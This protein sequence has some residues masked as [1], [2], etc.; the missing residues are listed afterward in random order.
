MNQAII[1]MDDNTYRIEDGF[2]RL[3][4]VIGSKQALLIDSGAS[5]MDVVA[6]AREVTD[7]PL[8]LLNT[9]GDMDHVARNDL[10]SEFYMHPSDYK[11]CSIEQKFPNSNLIPIEDGQVLDLGNRVLKLISIPGHTYGSVAI[12]D[13]N[14]KRLFV[15]DS[16]QSGHIFMFGE[17]RC[18]DKFKASLEKLMNM[19]EEVKELAASHDTPILPADHIQK[20]YEAWQLVCDGKLES[21]TME[22]HGH[23][24]KSY[25]TES[26]GFYI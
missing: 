24:V 12:Y 23:E 19:K 16:V 10:F 26:C 7:L 2:V 6:L 21:S 1:K 17:H 11:N 13:E 22:L 20:V 18:P 25:T 9:H 14:Y 5:G 8:M 15:G 3:F 4:L